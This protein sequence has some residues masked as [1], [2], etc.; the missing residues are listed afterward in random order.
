MGFYYFSS[1]SLIYFLIIYG[2]GALLLLWLRR[3]LGTWRHKNL[4]VGLL[5][6]PLV[7]FPWTEGLWIAYQF[8]QACKDAG[9]FIY[10]KVQVE[11]FYD[12]TRTTH[13]G[14]PTPQAAQSFEQ[15]GYRF[16]EM[17]GREKFVRIE[18]VDGQWVPTILD[19]PTARYHYQNPHSHTPVGH[20]VTQIEYTVTDSTSREILGKELVFARDAPWFYV[21]L[22]RPLKLCYGK[23]D[24]KG[25]LYVNVLIPE[26][27]NSGGNKQ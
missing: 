4:L 2:V 9:T 18:K 15:S 21:G 13:A 5:A 3:T 22:D 11:G 26:S 25:S 12:D 23:R 10:K 16:F 1:L 14:T 24:V 27:S 6:V 17:R 8:G 19:H 7:L 20:R